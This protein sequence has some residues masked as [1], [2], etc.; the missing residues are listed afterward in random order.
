MQNKIY[1]V[2]GKMDTNSVNLLKLVSEISVESGINFFIIGA[3][4]KEILLNIYY[5]LR[6]SRFTEDIDICVAVN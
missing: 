6:T 3:F 4:A 1:D 5:G 2:T